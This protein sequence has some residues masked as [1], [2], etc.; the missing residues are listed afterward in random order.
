MDNT[1]ANEKETDGLLMRTERL[2]KGYSIAGRRLEIRLEMSR[3]RPEWG[4]ANQ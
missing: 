3:L 2:S 4:I 1:A